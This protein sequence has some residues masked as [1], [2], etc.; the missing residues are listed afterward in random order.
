MMEMKKRTPLPPVESPRPVSRKETH[1][2]R[3]Y[4]CVGGPFDKQVHMVR[5]KIVDAAKPIRFRCDQAA[6]LRGMSGYYRSD[7]A[8]TMQWICERKLK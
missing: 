4:L 6:L 2:Q 3:A 1:Q 8:S 5:Q 7:T